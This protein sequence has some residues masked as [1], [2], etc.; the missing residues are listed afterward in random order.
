MYMY[1]V[2][3]VYGL[4]GRRCSMYAYV[5][6]YMH[7]VSYV[8]GLQNHGCGMYACMLCI[9]CLW[10]CEVIAAVYMHVCVYMY[11]YHVSYVYGL[12]YNVYVTYILPKYYIYVE[13]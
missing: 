7:N 3:Y 8:H 13:L 12:I 1:Y 10:I 9:V 4:R 5:C 11:V 2:S 6:M